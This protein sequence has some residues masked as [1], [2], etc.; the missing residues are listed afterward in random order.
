MRWTRTWLFPSGRRS[1]RLQSLI[2]NWP[3]KDY[4]TISGR[5]LPL[6]RKVGRPI[7]N[8]LLACECMT[9]ILLKLVTS[10]GNT[11]TR[12]S[13]SLVWM[14]GGW[15]LLNRIIWILSPKIWTR[16]PTWGLSA[17]YVMPIRSCPL[18][19]CT[20]ISVPCRQ[21][22]VCLSWPVRAFWDSSV[23]GLMCG[24]VTWVHHG[25]PCAIRYRPDW[26]SH[27][28]ACPTGTT[29][30]AV[31]LPGNIIRVGMTERLLRIRFIRNFMYV[32][33][34][35]ELLH[36]WCVPTVLT[37][38]ARFINSAKKANRC[39][40]PLRRW[41]ACVIPFCPTFT[42]R[43]GMWVIASLR[44]CVRSSWISQRTRRCGTWMTN[45][46]LERLSL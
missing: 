35:S 11:W 30:L 21:I 14:H 15:I 9:L 46:C 2:G 36:R 26:T 29:T 7:W 3:I 41:Y 28:V 6:G 40:M 31:S 12:E 45:I 19:E 24:V 39:M 13:L 8:I 34:S 44:S 1:V 32:G 43:R 23:M 27:F 17:K 37:P 4:C 25:R 10:T 22:N 16:R 33:Y 42:L 5:G 20:T 38:H 18:A